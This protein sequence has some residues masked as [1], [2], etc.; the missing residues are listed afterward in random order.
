MIY[1][2]HYHSDQGLKSYGL[3]CVLSWKSISSTLL[4]TLLLTNMESSFE[5]LINSYI[6]TRV[7]IAE[8]FLSE[9]LVL[10]L[11]TNLLEL[12]TQN[13]MHAAGTGNTGNVVHDKKTRGDFIYWLDRKHNNM[14]E[15]AFLDQMDAFVSHLNI[16]CYTGIK[17]YEFHYTIYQQGAFYKKHIDQFQNDSNRAFSIVSYLNT[18]WQEEDGGNLCIHHSNTKQYISPTNGKTVFFK[19]NEIEHE[20][21][22]TYA[23]RLSITGWLK[24]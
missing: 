20:V 13:H 16:H 18:N 14:Y 8:H 7:G 12:H 1:K 15:N 11:K 24:T 6:E 3:R 5:E 9:A 4:H 22:P 17:S 23:D 19:S 2:N 10:N 21:L